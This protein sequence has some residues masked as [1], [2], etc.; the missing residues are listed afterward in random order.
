M[1]QRST[2]LRTCVGCGEQRDKR[3]LVRIVRSAEGHVDVDVTGKANGRGAYIC[4]KT[5]CFDAA[6]KRNRIASALRVNLL[7]DDV[8]RL[9]H[10]LE[11]LLED[12][13]ST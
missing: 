13:V 2:P 8:L 1:K 9:R 3:E 6:V 12:R 10:D 11:G 7:E 5:D 4:P